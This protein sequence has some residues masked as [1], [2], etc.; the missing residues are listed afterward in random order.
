MVRSPS[1]ATASTALSHRLERARSR[2]RR[3]GAQPA[4]GR[5]SR[6]APAPSVEPRTEARLV[7]HQ[8]RIH[9]GP[10]HTTAR[11]HANR[12]GSSMLLNVMV[13][14]SERGAADEAAGELT[15]AGHVVLRCHDPGASAFPCRG[16]EDRSK[17]PLWSHRV[18]VAL[19]VRSRPRSQPAPQEDGVRCALMH[20]PVVAGVVVQPLTPG[21]TV[22]SS[23]RCEEVAAARPRHSRVQ[24]RRYGWR[25][26]RASRAANG[27][28]LRRSAV[29]SHTRPTRVRRRARLEPRR[30]RRRRFAPLVIGR[31][32][33]RQS[34]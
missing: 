3:G 10:A 25:P 26:A 9:H 32:P 4:R 12:G 18:D 27:S 11:S 22:T 29:W 2:R 21:P 8:S 16:I 23:A 13:L 24:D 7:A 15:A 31:P 17:C 5:A 34:R 19:T 14:Q 6:A 20:H 30:Y 33:S 28:L 1:N